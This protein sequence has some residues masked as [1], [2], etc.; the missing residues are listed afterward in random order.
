MTARLDPT[1]LTDIKDYGS[2]EVDACFNC[3]NCTAVCS[4]TTAEDNFPRKLIR[5]AQLGLTDELVGSPELWLCYNCG[6]CSETCPRQAEPAAFMMAARNYA[7]ASY[8]F[9][10]LGKIFASRPVLGGLMLVLIN[11]ML[12]L[13]MYTNREPIPGGELKLFEFLP[14]EFVHTAGL[15]MLIIVGTL[16]VAVILNMIAK[17]SKNAGLTAGSFF[18]QDR[19]A[20]WQSL[21]EAVGRQALGQKRYRQDCEDD[22]DTQPWFLSKWFVHAAAIWGFL[23]LLL[24]TILD[25]VLDIVKIKSTGTFMPLWH[26]IRLLGT[27]AGAL[28]IYGVTTLIVKRLRKVDKAH[29]NSTFS[30]WVFLILLWVSGMTGFIVELSLYLPQATWGY[31][32]LLVHIAFS[33]EL[34]LLLPFTKFAHA[35]LRTTALFVHAL[36]PVP[37]EKMVSQPVG[38]D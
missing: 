28:M 20:W 11:L 23:G 34:V 3:G 5:Y 35:L 21:W 36:K 32:M 13:F 22:K 37:E 26:P 7:I 2:V 24:A 14:Y 25:Y 9:T 10:G 6:E 1:L 30:D 17:I 29:A 18:K 16:G 38:A 8:D 15:W 33:A 4:L 12:F 27:V 19:K 31:W